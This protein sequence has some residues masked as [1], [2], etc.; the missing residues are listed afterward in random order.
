MPF[1]Y[2]RWKIGLGRIL[3]NCFP[4]AEVYIIYL[5]PASSRP[6]LDNLHRFFHPGSH[7]KM[8]M[9]KFDKIGK[10][11]DWGVKYDGKGNNK[12]R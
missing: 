1:I 10:N 12:N 5:T 8:M 9:L 11:N 2:V 6:K 3:P 7:P 4:V